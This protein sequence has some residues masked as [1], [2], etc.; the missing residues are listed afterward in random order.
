MNNLN[1]ARKRGFT[2]I[3][4]LVVIAII[5]ILAAILFP[6]FAK[7]REKARQITCASNLKQ[8]GIACLS[9][10]EDYDEQLPS[11]WSGPNGYGASNPATGVYKW[12]DAVYPYVKSVGVYHCPD[13][14]GQNGSTGNYVFYQNLTGANANYYGSYGMNSSYWGTGSVSTKGPGNGPGIGLSQLNSPSTTIWIGDGDGS[15]Q[16]DWQNAGQENTASSNG[17]TEIGSTGSEGDGALTFRHGGPD[18]ANAL[19]CDGHVKALNAGQAEVTAKE[20]DNNT[21]NYLFICNGQ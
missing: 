13:D 7:A 8:L 11:S 6:V 1:S 16:I 3:E 18:L 10:T 15:Y 5:A 9:Y 20:S 12:M 2:L 19:Y 21:Y 17:F 14:A 4:L